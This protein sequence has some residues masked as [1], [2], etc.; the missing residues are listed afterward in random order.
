M[1]CPPPVPPAA[2]SVEVGQVCGAVGPG[3]GQVGEEKSILSWSR[4]LEGVAAAQAAGG[5]SRCAHLDSIFLGN[6]STQWY[7]RVT[8]IPGPGAETQPLSTGP[9]ERRTY[10]CAPEEWKH[11]SVPL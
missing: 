2:L 4:G 8:S 1:L 11:A 7:V 9:P 10:L 5:H 3:G 6:F